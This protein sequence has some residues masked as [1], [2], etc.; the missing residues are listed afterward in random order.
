[1]KAHGISW[2]AAALGAAM[3]VACQKP[4]SEPEPVAPSDSGDRRA[5]LARLLNPGSV[6]FIGGDAAARAISQ[7]RTLGFEGAM[8][9]VHPTRDEVGGLPAFASVADLPATPDVAFVGVN[10]HE[11]VRQVAALAEA[12]TGTAVCY[13]SGFAE[14]GTEGR[15]LQADLISAAGSM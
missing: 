3:I 5:R 1:M 11:S 6:A 13:A 4:A 7:C 2:I 12:G 10:R 8:W 14:I 9:P 15:F